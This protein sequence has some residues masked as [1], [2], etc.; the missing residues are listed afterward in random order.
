MP[1][2][3]EL[4]ETEL[5]TPP[6][7][8]HPEISLHNFVR[9]AWRVI[10]PAVP[11]IDGWHIDQ[12]C[13]HLEW[14]STGV[15][16]ERDLLINE[17]PGSS[18]SIITAIMW[19]AW[20]WTWAPWIRWLTSSYDVALALRDAVTTRRLMQSDWYQAQIVEPW[21]FTSDQNVKGYY[22]NDRTGFRVATSMDGGNTGWHVHRALVDDPH[23]VRKAESDADRLS[24]L[25]SWKEV[26]PSRADL[27]GAT[28]VLIGQRVH[29]EDCT[30]DWL[31]R[32]RETVHHLE[33]KEEFERPPLGHAL[34]ICSM[35]GVQHD[36]RTVDGELLRPDRM[37]ANK[38]ELRK[39]ELGPYA[40]AA[41]HQQSPTPRAGKMLNPMWFPQTPQLDAA[42]VD[43]VMAFDMNYSESGDSDWT[44][45]MLAA[46][47]RSAILPR[48]HIVDIFRQHLAEEKH[49]VEVGDWI[50]LWKP[51]LV[52][53]EKRAFEKQGAT[54][55]FLRRLRIYLEEK[56]FD[57]ELEPVEADSDKVTR[58]MII[59][60]RAKAGLITVDKRAKWWPLL[61]RELSTFP[62]S[63]HDDQVD[64]L[65]H[66][67]RL[68][69]EKLQNV[70]AKRQ[71]LGQ[72]VPVQYV[73]A[74]EQSADWQK[75]MASGL[76]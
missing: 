73:E 31:E 65:A 48:I 32:E 52:G 67:V 68:V 75:A 23:N 53:I 11:F 59:P 3:P 9:L 69:V 8:A 30:A 47:E 21:H 36:V 76:R 37:P 35:T 25:N 71:M 1:L 28:R 39:I 44:V 50:F 62:K 55:D 13:Q 40:Y 64:A 12:L 42:T 54:R 26:Y 61:S 51:V 46:V 14:L 5:W 74:T 72:S 49:D 27:P 60:G 10:E 15:L 58:A 16:P 56:R 34:P 43:L 63:A 20:E 45:G 24:T 6:P 41:Q 33:I 7:D 29:E 17:P 66:L 18:K 19:P 2:L 70:R 38:V 22:L 4:I 57:C